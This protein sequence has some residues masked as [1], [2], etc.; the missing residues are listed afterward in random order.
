MSRE[1]MLGIIARAVQRLQN[2]GYHF[3]F[4]P[5]VAER[6]CDIASGFPWFVHAIGQEALLH[7]YSAR[8]R[9]VEPKHLEVAI[10]TLTT[11]RF[12]QQFSDAYQQA[13]K[14][15]YNREVVLRCMAQWK[16]RDIPTSEIYPIAKSL[17][18]SN[19]AEYRKQLCSAAAGHVLITPPFQERGVVRF[20]N[21]MFKIYI[22]LRRSLYNGVDRIVADAWQ[23][24]HS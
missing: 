9:V 20:G 8:S 16:G 19:P 18:V 3:Q 4:S 17:G 24:S 15:S 14:D 23:R 6:L 11:S 21:E 10:R 1:E 22:R 7:A 13:V 2:R 12:A 5:E